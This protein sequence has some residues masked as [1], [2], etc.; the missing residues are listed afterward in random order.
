MK[1]EVN[2]EQKSK[3]RHVFEAESP[4]KIVGPPFAGA[5]FDAA[6]ECQ[7]HLAVTVAALGI[8]NQECRAGASIKFGRRS[9]RSQIDAEISVESNGSQVVA[10]SKIDTGGKSRYFQKPAQFRL[11]TDHN[12]VSIEVESAANA[13]CA[14]R[15]LNITCTYCGG[16]CACKT[17]S[18]KQ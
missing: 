11:E 13:E 6:G 12:L 8:D 2:P 9:R 7:A 14:G 18:K 17:Y 3:L 5:E 10:E 15:G 1:L 16:N 4:F